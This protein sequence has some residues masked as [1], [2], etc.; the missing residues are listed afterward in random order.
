[1]TSMDRDEAY[2]EKNVHEVYQQIAKHFSA[3]RYKVCPTTMNV[4]V[5][6]R[7]LTGAAMADCG[8][9]SSRPETGRCRA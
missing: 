5:P 6:A 8:T 1:M 4:N 2:E 7:Q 3:T 9:L